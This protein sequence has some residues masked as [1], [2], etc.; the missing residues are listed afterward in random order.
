[1]HENEKKEIGKYRILELVFLLAIG[2]RCYSYNT[3]YF[4]RITYS[5]AYYMYNEILFLCIS[6]TAWKTG[7]LC[8]YFP[9]AVA[10]VILFFTTNNFE[11]TMFN[12]FFLIQ[13]IF[14]GIAVLAG[15]YQYNNKKNT[16]TE[17]V[18]SN[19]AGSSYPIMWSIRRMDWKYG[20][21]EEC[22]TCSRKVYLGSARTV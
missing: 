8:L 18:N 7:I 10:G 4:A 5:I 15:D 11:T 14:S 13:A 3:L 1:M 17:T 2:Y 12:V 22:D 16:N 9:I 20:K 19:F 6:Y 21:S